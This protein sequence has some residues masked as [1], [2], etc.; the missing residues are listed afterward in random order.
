MPVSTYNII[1]TTNIFTEPPGGIVMGLQTCGLNLN[2]AQKE[3]Y[4]HGTPGFPCAAYEGFYTDRPEQTIPWHWHEELEI[5][6]VKSGS[7]K[8]QIPSGSFL[9]TQGDCR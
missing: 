8:F 3:L 6:Y 5:A 1:K 9:L 7:I 2:N 4:P